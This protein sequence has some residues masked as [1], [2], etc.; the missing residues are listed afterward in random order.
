MASLAKYRK[1]GK[2]KA[3]RQAM[4]AEEVEEDAKYNLS[5]ILSNCNDFKNEK[6]A[7]QDMMLKRGGDCFFNPKC[8]P[9][10]A[11]EGIE[12]IWGRAKARYRKRRAQT[13]G[14]LSKKDFLELVRW[15]ISTSGSDATLTKDFALRAARKARSYMVA[16][17]EI[18]T[19]KEEKGEAT[20][21]VTLYSDIERQVQALKMRTYNRHRGVSE[22]TPR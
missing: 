22:V 19:I 14:D 15:S 11:G 13:A 12:Y 8:Y 16:Y 10:L 4:T 20:T 18:V 5:S 3:Q 2:S 21:T 1:T 9:E 7:V 17:A 6:S